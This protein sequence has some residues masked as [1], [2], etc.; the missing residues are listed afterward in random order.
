MVRLKNDTDG[1]DAGP[2]ALS[3]NV[4]LLGRLV[5]RCCNEIRRK[6]FRDP[7]P[8]RVRRSEKAN[9]KGINAEAFANPGLAA[10]VVEIEIDPVSMEPFVRG[11]WLVADGG[12]ILNERRARRVLRTGAIQALG[13][14]CR[15]MVY[16]EEGKIPLELYQGY[17]IIPPAEIPPIKVDFF[18]SDAAEPKGIGEL[19]FGC[20]PAAYLQA[21]SQAM[22]H[23]FEKIPL[24]VLEILEAWKLKQ[25]E[26]RQ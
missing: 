23:P 25:S 20:I 26:G 12:K 22:D 2:A 5:E 11:I 18:W 8:I 24:S 7:L 9:K 1:P 3:R 4:G 10:A 13:W 17:D 6:R 19:P 21:V 15:E 14:A 16:Y